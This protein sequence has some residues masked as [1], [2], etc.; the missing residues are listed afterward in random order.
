VFNID[1]KKTERKGFTLIELL[2]VISIIGMLA[3]TV[4]AATNR[5]REKARSGAFK[6]EIQQLQF[7][8]QMYF[9]NN[10]ERWVGDV[11]PTPVFLT[12]ISSYGTTETTLTSAVT[13]NQC[14]TAGTSMFG[15]TEVKK[16]LDALIKLYPRGVIEC[17]MT[18]DGVNSYWTIYMMTPPSSGSTWNRW[19]MDNYIF[20]QSR[21]LIGNTSGTTNRIIRVYPGAGN[22]A[23]GIPVYCARDRNDN[24]ADGIEYVT[25]SPDW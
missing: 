15:D 21:N 25:T 3:S 7:A 11:A 10:G 22:I 14:P 4:L 13:G 8:L 6:K 2:V 17:L 9:L 5:A 16:Q 23:A 18:N 12:S 24:P 19:C 1:H 20:T